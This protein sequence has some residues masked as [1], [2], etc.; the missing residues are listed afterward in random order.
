M[1]ADAAPPA[2]L[3]Q[4]RSASGSC[5]PHRAR[6]TSRHARHGARPPRPDRH[7][8]AAARGSAHPHSR[9]GRDPGPRA[10]VRRL[11]H[12]PA[13]RRGRTPATTPAPR[14]RPPGGWR[15][16]RARRWLPTARRRPARRHRLATR[17]LRHLP[18]LP[19]RRREP[20]HGGALHR[21]ARRR[22]LRGVRAGARGFRVRA[23]RRDWRR[24][25]IPPALRRHHRLPRPAPR[26]HPPRLPP[27]PL[28]LRRVGAHRHPGRPPPRLPGL[29]SR[30]PP[31]APAAHAKT[32]SRTSTSAGRR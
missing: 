5:R 12:R 15:R 10:A 23:A 16:R 22:R 2:R 3:P 27:R 32:P 14:P 29:A 17:D 13:R 25:G 31:A 19:A 4:G 7:A 1:A 8:A 9:T 28:R 11:P 18:A 21:L 26:Q 20:L 6:Y 24:G 30:P